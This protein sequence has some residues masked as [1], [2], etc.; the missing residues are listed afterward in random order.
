MWSGVPIR[1]AGGDELK[2]HQENYSAGDMILGGLTAKGLIPSESPILFYDLF[3]EYEK[4][5]PKSVTGKIY[6]DMVKEKKMQQYLMLILMVMQSGR[7]MD[8]EAALK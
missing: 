2:Q 7:M 4:P 6:S 5:H 3:N 1:A 8:F